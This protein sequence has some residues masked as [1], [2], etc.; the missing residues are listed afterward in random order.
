MKFLVTVI[1]LLF[2]SAPAQALCI[3]HGNRYAKT[4]FEDEFKDSDVVIKAN[5]LMS[6]DIGHDEDR[7]VIYQLKVLR[8]YKGK[9]TITPV[10][11]SRRDS[12]A[13]Y[14]DTGKTYLLFLDHIEG[15]EWAKDAPG[16]LVVN[17][18]CGQSREWS[19]VPESTKRKLIVLAKSPS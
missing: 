6:H 13:F 19:K 2:F 11:Y 18:N 9:S 4:S 10:Y 8:R 12:G 15:T 5:V 17:Y 14:L 7:A 16:A 3:Y 1:L